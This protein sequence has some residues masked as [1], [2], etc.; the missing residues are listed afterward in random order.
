MMRLSTAILL[1][2][3]ALVV[4]LV[5][6]VRTGFRKKLPVGEMPLPVFVGLNVLI[7]G[8]CFVTLL[9]SLRNSTWAAPLAWVFAIAMVLNGLG[10]IGMM[11]IKKAYFPGGITAFLLLPLS[12]YLIVLLLRG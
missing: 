11:V 3:V 6:E 2:I 4:H 1:L 12:A 7:Y 10:H 8:F 9:L 5:E